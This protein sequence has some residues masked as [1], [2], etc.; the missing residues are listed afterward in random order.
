MTTFL[1]IAFSILFILYIAGTYNK[2]KNK[3]DTESKKRI[4]KLTQENNTNNINF[5][6]NKNAT[7]YCLIFD[8]ETTGLIKDF[9]IRPS[10]KSI[11]ENPDNFPE[12]VS[13]CWAL[14]SRNEEIITEKN[15]II[16]KE[17]IPIESV[18]I[19]NITKE[20]SQNKG[21]EIQKALEELFIDA[22]KCKAIVGH[23]IIFDKHVIEAEFI[24]IGMK[25]PFTNK[26][27]YDTMKMGQTFMQT[28]KFPK[29][30]ELCEFIYGK[31]I[32]QHLNSHN[33]MYDT[34]FTA[35]S[36]FFLKNKKGYY[37]N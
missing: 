8:V 4:E 37:W 14:F 25:K 30:S 29:L 15:Y 13:I 18:R 36:F 5:K 31:E 28:N 7:P 27:N 17:H 21:I 11:R 3:S 16:K 2:I 9:S 20:I 34:F 22:E 10:I 1:I 24:R 19:H 6:T 35:K 23:N 26:T 12:I 33:S 32:L